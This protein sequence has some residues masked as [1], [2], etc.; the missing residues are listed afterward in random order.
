MAPDAD[1]DYFQ[2]MNLRN[3]SRTMVQDFVR[4]DSYTYF[5]YNNGKLFAANSTT[6]KIVPVKLVA[7]KSASVKREINEQNVA[8]IEL[9]QPKEEV[10]EEEEEKDTID[11]SQLDASLAESAVEG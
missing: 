3:H 7:K 10:D 1:S 9:T 11:E 8:S 4:D 5:A 2:I 6:I